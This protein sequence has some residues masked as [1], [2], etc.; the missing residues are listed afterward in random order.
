MKYTKATEKYTEQIYNLVQDTIITIYPK[1][2]PQEVVD[3]F[4][5][6]HSKE[7]ILEDIKNGCVGILWD[8]D[9]LVGT[10]SYKENHITRVYVAPAFQGQGYGSCIM[11]KLEN[12]ISLKY[13]AVYLDASLPASSLY[14][15][16]GYRTIKHNKWNVENDVVLIYDV[17]KKQL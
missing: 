7:N 3:F 12:M 10:G 16:R 5:K 1:Y 17:M 9:N 8:C 11:Q 14:G 13:N 6:L 4:C 15:H 2:Y